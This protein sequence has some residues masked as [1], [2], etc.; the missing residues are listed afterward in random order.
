VV[1]I[2]TPLLVL[3]IPIFDILYTTV[4][5]V[6]NGQVKSVKEWLEYAGRD[7]FHHRLM[8]LGLGVRQTVWFIVLL[9]VCLGLGAWTMR[10]TVTSV[11]TW[12]LL[13]QSVM[14]FAIVVVLMLLGRDIADNRPGRG[15]RV[16][17]GG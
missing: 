14:V 10:R 5:R 8:H 16:G 7:H 11:G 1:A 6:R 15:S 17:D 2:S 9:N 3:G 13:A 12:L 4:S